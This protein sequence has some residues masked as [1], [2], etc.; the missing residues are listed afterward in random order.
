[1]GFR[2]GVICQAFAPR[3]ESTQRGAGGT[4]SL[5]GEVERAPIVDGDQGIAHLAASPAFLKQIAQGEEVPGGLRHLGSLDHEV[6]AVHPVTDEGPLPVTGALALGDLGLVVGKDVVDA[7]AVDVDGL[8]EQA[9]RHRAALDVPSGR[10]LPHGLSQPT[11][12]SSGTQAFQRAKSA[13][14]S[15]SYS[16]LATR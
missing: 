4:E 15:F 7:A 2:S 10:P 16:S 5:E 14:A 3:I 8:A 9:C 13:T 12:P 1:L 11:T 6:G